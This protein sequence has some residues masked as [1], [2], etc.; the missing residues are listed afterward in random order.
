MVS[1]V[2]WHCTECC[3]INFLAHLLLG[4][5]SDAE[6]AGALLGD[7]VKGPVAPDW[8]HDLAHGIRLHRAIDLF[9]D[10][11]ACWRASKQRFPVGQRRFAGITV[12]LLYD[13]LLARD[14]HRHDHR[15][16]TDFSAQ[17]YAS[18]AR[19]EA[20]FPPRLQ[21]MFPVMVAEDWLTGYASLDR[22]LAQL[23]RMSTRSPRLA[24]L[25]HTTESIAAIY[26]GL[27]HDFEAFFPDLKEFATQRR[28]KGFPPASR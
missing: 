6:R 21:R 13:H 19:Y 15:A 23:V 27:A 16:L 3:A 8:P 25:A 9:T 4:G 10:A 17:A 11:H 5:D 28:A 7:F 2:F 24:P 22:T 1:F 14:W 18:I 12:D 20:H 26:D